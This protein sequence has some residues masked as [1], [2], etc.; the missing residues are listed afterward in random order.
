MEPLQNW[1]LDAARADAQLVNTG[2]LVPTGDLQ[3][4]FPLGLHPF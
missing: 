3:P 1:D 2:M 4:V